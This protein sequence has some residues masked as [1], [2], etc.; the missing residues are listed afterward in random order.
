MMDQ[1]FLRMLADEAT[2][3]A[4]LSL[5]A[6]D[7]IDWVAVDALADTKHGEDAIDALCSAGLITA[8]CSANLRWTPPGRTVSINLKYRVCGF[9]AGGMVDTGEVSPRVQHKFEW[10]D[11]PEYDGTTS[12]ENTTISAEPV[13]FLLMRKLV[14]SGEVSPNWPVDWDIRKDLKFGYCR[15]LRVCLTDHGKFL[16]SSLAKL[17]TQAK[18]LASLVGAIR[19]MDA[20]TTCVKLVHSDRA[21]LNLDE[22][23][24]S[25]GRMKHQW[26]AANPGLTDKRFEAIRIKNHARV[27]DAGGGGRGPWQF[28][29][30]LCYEFGLNCPEFSESST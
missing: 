18:R 25:A 7:S 17:R 19:E 13:Q 30:S 4:A 2:A 5:I 22:D 27:R 24:Y 26:I 10:S 12:T 21:V 14:S 9:L 16:R 8:E 28:R 11:F 29:Q 23:R 20:V 15:T 6:S 1:L 3:E